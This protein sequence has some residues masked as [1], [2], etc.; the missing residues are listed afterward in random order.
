MDGLVS[1][2]SGSVINVS[3]SSNDGWS[4]ATSSRAGKKFTEITV[5]H[6]NKVKPNKSALGTPLK[7]VPTKP[8]MPD[9]FH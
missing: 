8:D 9:K 1:I 3:V 4:I 5:L 2:V 6:N 7:S